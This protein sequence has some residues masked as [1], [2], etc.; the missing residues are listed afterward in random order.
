[1]K[2]SIEASGNA[3]FDFTRDFKSFNDLIPIPRLLKKTSSGSL[4]NFV[5]RNYKKGLFWLLK[6]RGKQKLTEIARCYLAKHL[7]GYF[8]WYTWSMENWGVKWDMDV[9][10]VEKHRIEFDVPWCLPE[11]ILYALFDKFPE[12]E[13][14]G[15]FAEEQPGWFSGTFGSDE[16]SPGITS[17]HYD[18]EGSNEA[19]ERYF[20]FW[21][22]EEDYQFIN[23]EYVYI[24]E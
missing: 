20:S 7:Y 11:P 18:V 2:I 8:D 9:V 15:E 24:D 6:N 16:H 19:Y 17:F 13:F 3:D 21:G 1:M 4:S 5:E 10:H 23:G 14:Y 22:G 12:M